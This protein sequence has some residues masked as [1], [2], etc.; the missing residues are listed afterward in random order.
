MQIFSIPVL[1]EMTRS[2]SEINQNPFDAGVNIR[3]RCEQV[4]TKIRLK[5][6]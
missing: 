4:K 1:P 5:E 2:L 3:S 6:R